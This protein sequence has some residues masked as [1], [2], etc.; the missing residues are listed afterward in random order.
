MNQPEGQDHEGVQ[1]PALTFGSTSTPLTVIPVAHLPQEIPDGG[2]HG[3]ATV[4]LWKAARR[5]SRPIL[6]LAMPDVRK[7]HRKGAA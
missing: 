6:P 2:R 5:A 3:P 7:D 1:N 4:A